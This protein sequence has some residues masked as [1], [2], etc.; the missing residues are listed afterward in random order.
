MTQPPATS[1]PP[2]EAAGTPAARKGE[3]SRRQT[4]DEVEPGGEA[5]ERT[6]RVL[7]LLFHFPPLGGVAVPRNVRNVEYLPRFGWTPVVVAPSDAAGLMDPDTL[8]LVPLATRVIRARCPEPRDLR[9]VVDPLRRAV[10]RASRVGTGPARAPSRGEPGSGEPP[11]PPR[12]DAGASG[13]PAPAWAWRLYRLLAFP[14]GQVG[15]LPF[16]VVAA[17][18]AH[19]AGPFDVIYSTSAPITAHVVAGI[20]KRL[21]GVPW[22]AEFRDPWLGSPIAAALGGRQP[23]LHRRLQ[24]RLERWIVH[25]ADRIVFLSSSTAGAYRHRYPDAAEMVTITNGHDR[26]DV[27]PHAAGRHGPGRFRIVSAGSLRPAELKVFLEAVSRLAARRPSLADELEI[28]FYGH[29]STECQ[30]VA[31]RFTSLDPL[32]T[33]VQFPGFVPRSIALEAIA[34]ADA[35]LVMLGAGPGMGQFVPGKLFEIIGQDKQVLAVLPPGDAREILAE[36]DWGVVAEPDAPDIERAIER[37]LALPPPTRRADPKGA[38][39]R[40]ALARRLADTLRA[41]A[42]APHDPDPAAARPP[43]PQ[44]GDPLVGAAPQRNELSMKVTPGG[45][46]PSEL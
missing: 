11:W 21:T 3:R 46:E 6:R 41:A 38:Y 1:L 31:D 4:G 29:V 28:V 45:E 19:R 25:S 5:G 33:I 42:E 27:V 40:V 2:P 44:A 32:G 7:M 18:R 13:R 39:D 24:V 16:A 26:G 37:L 17:V 9:R 34:G 15:W 23:W 22:V 20:V 43:R 10:G 8:A 35:A 36:L 12:D 14:D 30:A